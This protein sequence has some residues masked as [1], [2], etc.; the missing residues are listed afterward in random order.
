MKKII[1]WSLVSLFALTFVSCKSTLPER[2]DSFVAS[3]EQGA[4]NYSKEEWARAD[5][6]FA[7]LR[8]EYDKKKES[9]DTEQKHQ[10]EAAIGKYNGLRAKGGLKGIFDG[11]MDGVNTL[12][13][14]VKGAA[15]NV[16]GFVQGLTGSGSE[17]AAEPAPAE[18]A[19]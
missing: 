19:K 4:E 7:H 14:G 9:L 1:V 13:D 11:L 18:P 12:I 5:T 3:V 17:S 8:K 6:T 15:K 2:F 16:D 10:I